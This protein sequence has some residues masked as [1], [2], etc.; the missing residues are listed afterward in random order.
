MALTM[1][2]TDRNFNTS[3]YDPAG[4]GDPVLYQHLFL[5]ITMLYTIPAIPLIGST[6]PFRF[7]IFNS[8]YVLKYPNRPV[9]TQSFLEWFIGFSEG[10]GSFIVNSRGVSIF[11]ITQ[12]TIDIQVLQYI[13]ATLGFGRVIKQGPHT[14]RFVVEDIGSIALLIAIFNGNM[15]FPLKHSSFAAFLEAFNLRGRV[16]QV[17]LIETLVLPTVY[18]F[19]LCGVTDAEGCFSLSLLGNSTAYRFRFL[20]TQL[21]ATNLVILIHLTGLIGGTVLSHSVQNV[22]ELVVNGARNMELV[23]RYFDAHPLITK[24]PNH[25]EFGEKHIHLL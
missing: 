3:F 9:P 24:K 7:G 12:A 21:G 17:V 16:L 15:V 8:L 1:I 25:I 5:T 6:S 20:L 19:W 11:V 4:G 10:D 13:Q 14:S 2:L 18:D 22:N 23:F